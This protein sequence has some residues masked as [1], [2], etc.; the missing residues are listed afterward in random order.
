[1]SRPV[2]PVGRG[3]GFTLIELLV[4]MA[5]LAIV[6]AIAIPSYT[7]YVTRSNRTE[8]KAILMNTAQALERCFTR[9]NA[10]D[11]DECNVSFPVDSENDHYQMAAGNQ[12]I[13]AAT[14]TLTAVPQ[15]SQATNDTE[16]ANFTLTHNGTRG[17]SGSGD[18][19]DCW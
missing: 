15:G 8:G 6:M 13:D 5:I 4:A 2:N 10:Y 17:V 7:T 12:T 18:V 1:M 14:Y 9:Y 11:S 3:M 19:E 16:C